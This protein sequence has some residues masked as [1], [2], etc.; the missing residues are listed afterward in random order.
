MG[1]AIS[2]PASNPQLHFSEFSQKNGSISLTITSA[3]VD[4]RLTLKRNNG[5]DSVKILLL[6]PRP[7][8]LSVPFLNILN[9]TLR[10]PADMNHHRFEKEHLFVTEILIHDYDTQPDI[11]LGPI[12][13]IIWNSFGLPLCPH[14]NEEGRWVL[15]H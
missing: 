15:P 4:E 5:N 8:F 7:I 3:N 2:N 13:D 10:L 1:K 12:F 6:Y 11:A 9:Q 14:Y